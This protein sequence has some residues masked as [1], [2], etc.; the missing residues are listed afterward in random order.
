MADSSVVNAESHQARHNDEAKQRR[1]E[2]AAAARTKLEEINAQLN[3]PLSKRAAAAHRRERKR[4]VA[5]LARHKY[6]HIEDLPTEIIGEI[7][8]R[9]LPEY[10]A[11][12]ALVGLD[13]PYALA[14]VCHRWREIVMD[15]PR[16]W[17]G[18]TI[19]LHN[20][21]LLPFKLDFVQKAL[22]R[23]KTRPLS[24]LLR[25]DHSI[26]ILPNVLRLLFKHCARW[27]HLTLDLPGTLNHAAFS[28]A[29]VEELPKFKTLTIA[30]T[31]R[32]DVHYIL[33][34]FLRLF[35]A[36]PQFRR[37]HFQQGRV[38]DT[39]TFHLLPL[40]LLT[41][42]TLEDVELSRLAAVL[43]ETRALV[44]CCAR[45]QV[46]TL[47]PVIHAFAPITLPSLKTLILQDLNI[48]TQ[49]GP[50]FLDALTLPALKFLEIGELLLGADPFSTLTLLVQRM[51]HN[52]LDSLFVGRTSHH[53]AS[54]WQNRSDEVV[55]GECNHALSRVRAIE[56]GKARSIEGRGL[57]FGTGFQMDDPVNDERT[58]RL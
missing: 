46:R 53:F 2:N 42:I 7:F 56:V 11:R 37:L 57:Y 54:Q 40:E 13:S 18:L 39:E 50:N 48:D 33:P 44:H 32:Y 35:V 51:A 12:S 52:K 16:F 36:A 22:E 3:E 9:V 29:A 14:E 17:A 34:Q 6:H 20:N 24:I 47:R 25:S 31:A 49:D 19:A 15:T 43:K 4:L 8:G 30:P 23:S 55:M 26:P 5:L 27:E 10:P 41:H 21:R 45:P 1:S 28:Y 38:A 58:W